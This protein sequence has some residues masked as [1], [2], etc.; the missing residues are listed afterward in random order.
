MIPDVSDS[1]SWLKANPQTIKGI[2]R[3]IEREGL[4]I[5]SNGVLSNTLHPKELGSSLTHKWITTDFAEVLLEFITPFDTSISYVLDFLRDTH[6][7]VAR[8][9]NKE[10]L[11]PMSMPCFIDKSEEIQVAQYGASNVG[12]MKMI[13]REGLKNRYG[14]SMQM[15]S[16]VHYNF[17][18]PLIFWKIRDG[19]TDEVNGKNIISN[20]YLRLIRN[21]YRYGWIIPYLFG[22]S[23]GACSSF[24]NNQKTD[25]PFEEGLSGLIYLPYATSLRLSKIGYNNNSHI[26]LNITF[27]N[28]EEYIHMIKKATK[29]TFS[30]YLKIGLK[31]DGKYLQLNTNILQIENELYSPI[32]PKRATFGDELPSDALIRGGIQYIEV[33]SLDLNPFSPIGINQEQACFLDL[34]LVWCTLAEESEIS[35]NELYYIQNN[36][37]L[38]VLE[39]RKP[40]IILSIDC[41][42]K[43]L[44]LKTFGKELFKDLKQIAETI[45]YNNKNR[46]YQNVCVKLSLSFDHPE[47]VYST[48]ILEKM[49]QYG[50]NKL[51][52]ILANK[53]SKILRKEPFKLLNNNFF[54][55]EKNQSWKQKKEIENA[56][57]IS[58]E[59]FL[60]NHLSR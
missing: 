21:Y 16:G 14:A 4:R 1:L 56:K 38:V 27:N 36:W 51:G 17:S 22:A 25:L 42:R 44:P 2:V 41:G 32:R 55:K 29:T 45:D 9:L 31:K 59:K 54:I 10:H 12:L 30:D 53:Y 48:Y 35:K 43:E 3:G 11:W 28:L 58:F 15:I 39:G 40:G 18:L 37:N 33:R 49:K 19:A 5:N 52:L 24:L 7:Y 47:L 60:E 6:R 13:Y 8:N 26:Q 50:I 46:Q 20:G 57:M 23:P 34:F